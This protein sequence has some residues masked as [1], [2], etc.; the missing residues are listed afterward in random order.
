MKNNIQFAAL[1]VSLLLLSSCKKDKVSIQ[2]DLQRFALESRIVPISILGNQAVMSF[3]EYHNQKDI[4]AKFEIRKASDSIWKEI[5]FSDKNNILVTKLS[6]KTKYKVRVGLSKNNETRY[7]NIDSFTTAN[8]FINYDKFLS[9]PA[10]LHDESNGVFSIEN[11]KHIIYGGG[12]TNQSALKVRFISV[13]NAN[14]SFVLDAS[15]INDSMI[16]FVI[17]ADI[18][19]NAPYLRNKIYSCSIADVPIIGYKSYVEKNFKV[20][21]DMSIVNKDIEI[22]S[23]SA[24]PFATCRTISFSGTFA[25]HETES[26]CPESYYNVSMRVKERRVLILDKDDLV[27]TSFHIM[28]NG[29][30]QCDFDGVA[31]ADFIALNKSLLYYHEVSSISIKTTLASGTYKAQVKQTMEDE[32]VVLSNKW[33]INF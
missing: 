23:F 26:V 5:T 25:T 29:K 21:A 3:I 13:S 28:P 30:A 19:P 6:T 15:I 31:I 9:G 8:F 7:S 12:F 16:S 27:V 14:D 33:T 4:K 2:D 10:K 18:I 11:A 24:E 1:F 32:S 17:P 20:S 22:T